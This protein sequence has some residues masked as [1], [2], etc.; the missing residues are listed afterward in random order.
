MNINFCIFI[1]FKKQKQKKN[2]YCGSLGDGSM[3]TIFLPSES[4]FYTKE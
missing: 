3:T 2:S 4:S 1:L